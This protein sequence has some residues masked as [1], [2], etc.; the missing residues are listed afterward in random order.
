VS[1]RDEAATESVRVI[2]TNTT[3]HSLAVDDT[4]VYIAHNSPSIAV[5]FAPSSGTAQNPA[6]FLTINEGHGLAIDD[7]NVIV[8]TA[9]M[10][11]ITARSPLDGGLVKVVVGPE[12]GITASIYYLVGLGS[13]WFFTEYGGLYRV[14]KN[15]GT[16]AQLAPGV[17]VD[18]S[19][20][21]AVDGGIICRQI[22]DDGG[23]VSV[24]ATSNN[25]V[26]PLFTGEHP[27]SIAAEGD[28][29]FI[30]LRGSDD[31]GTRGSLV[32]V[33]A[34]GGDAKVLD[35]DLVVQS[36]ESKSTTIAVSKTSIYYVVRP[37]PTASTVNILRLAR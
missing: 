35:D 15:G 9:E 8:S 2:A 18:H 10:G 11:T 32:Q 13:E 33:A 14:D 34:T 7:G 23:V 28:Q 17:H 24:V 20:L 5:D 21:A 1:R 26:T 27:E 37:T 6:T 30:L 3:G 4:N 36:S 25:Q 12:A 16:P 29:V 31:A 22:N 19:R